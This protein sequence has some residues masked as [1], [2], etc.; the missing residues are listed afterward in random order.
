MGEG[1]AAF[2]NNRLNKRARAF[3]EAL[4]KKKQTEAILVYNW[5]DLFYP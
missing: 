4:K 2:L 3:R 1:A 5:L